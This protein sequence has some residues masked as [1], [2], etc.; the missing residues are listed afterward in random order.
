MPNFAVIEGKNVINTILAESK[1]IAE[2]VTGKTCVEYTNE[3]AE[4]GG[5][6]VDGVFIQHKPFESW[7][8]NSNNQWEAPIDQ[9]IFDENNPKNYIWDESITKWVEIKE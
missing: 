3:S 2:E 9:P 1:T 5:T 6:Y 8:L 7:V 4:T